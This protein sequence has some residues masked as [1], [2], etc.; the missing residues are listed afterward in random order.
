MIRKFKKFR[1]HNIISIF[2]ITNEGFVDCISG[3]LIKKYSTKNKK[4]IIKEK[5]TKCLVY[6]SPYS[7][8][9]IFTRRKKI[10]N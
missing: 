3:T 4:M 6:F 2:F 9:I 10:I 8:R 5:Q 1:K 7:N